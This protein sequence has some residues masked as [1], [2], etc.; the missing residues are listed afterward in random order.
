MAS[1]RRTRKQITPLLPPL[2]LVLALLLP[3]VLGGAIHGRAG[4]LEPDADRGTTADAD[5]TD[6]DATE[7]DVTEAWRAEIDLGGPRD[8]PVAVGIVRSRT[9]VAGAGG[10]DLRGDGTDV[11]VRALVTRS[12]AQAWAASYDS[13][14]TDRA[15]ATASW[16]GTVYVGGSSSP[17]TG[18]DSSAFVRAHRLSD[19]SLRWSDATSTAD[20]DGDSE[21]YLDI[22]QAGGRLFAV[23]RSDDVILV[24][25]YRARSGT[26]LWEDSASAGFAIDETAYRVIATAD[27]VYVLG[28]RHTIGGR[29]V[30]FVVRGYDATTGQRLWETTMGGGIAFA[31]GIALSGKSLVAAGHNYQL[32]IGADYFRAFGLSPGAGALRWTDAPYD[33]LI[34]GS[35]TN[36]VAAHANGVAVAGAVAR[37]RTLPVLRSYDPRT[38]ALRWEGA[39]G[40]IKNGEIRGLASVGGTVFAVGYASRAARVDRDDLMLRAYDANDGSIVWGRVLQLGDGDAVGSAVAASAKHVVAAGTLERPADDR[41]WLLIAYRR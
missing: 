35:W 40:P 33:R 28:E 20:E 13:G 31:R 16:R 19:G 12:G 34:G 39:T 4:A 37:A 25:A 14:E 27:R 17:A 1:E 18:G 32:G 7:A 11:E 3:L 26:R 8:G 30:I 36:A 5:A 9:I 29:S 6:A 21:T 24:R 23:G 2:A 41:D 15:V 10:G 38:G 22:A